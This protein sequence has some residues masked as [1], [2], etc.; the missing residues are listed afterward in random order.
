MIALAARHYSRYL[1]RKL[2][3]LPYFEQW[4]LVCG[5]FH[6]DSVSL[7]PGKYTA[8]VP[9]KD[10]SWADPFPIYENGK[11]YVFIEE[12]IHQTNRGFISVMTM[13]GNGN[14]SMPIK[15]MEASHHLSYPFV[16]QWGREYFMVPESAENRT[17]D[18]YRCVDFPKI[19]ELSMT[20]ISDIFAVD[21]TMLYRNGKWWMFTSVRDNESDS[22]LDEL[23]L[24]YSDILLT[25]N[26][27]AHPNNPIVSD[28]RCSRSAGK[29]FVVGEDLYRPAQDCSTR[30]GHGIKLN[31]V[32]QLSEHSYSE[33]CVGSVDPPRQREILGMHTVNRAHGLTVMD[34]VVRRAKYWG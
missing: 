6:R 21:T 3:G 20:L 28:V 30:Y 22:Q 33:V 17:I 7:W 34:A 9:P 10:R 31:R 18:L 29:L 12:L 23:F 27:I 11:H 14:H 32:T 15:V 19:W 26:W 25:G 2:R 5:S 1:W 24:F 13:D 8:L 16:F 4:Q